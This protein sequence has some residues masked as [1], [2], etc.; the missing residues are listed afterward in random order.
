MKHIEKRGAPNRRVVFVHDHD[1]TRL[2]AARAAGGCVVGWVDGMYR[3]L[4][5]RRR[6]DG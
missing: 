6:G 2:E 5:P 1:E 3:V 4:M